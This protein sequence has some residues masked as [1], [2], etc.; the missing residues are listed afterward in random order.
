MKAELVRCSLVS[1]VQLGVWNH[2][3]YRVI[4]GFSV[5]GFVSLGVLTSEFLSHSVNYTVN[6]LSTWLQG[7]RLQGM[8]SIVCL[9]LSLWIWNCAEQLKY[10]SF[11]RV[12]YFATLW[13][14]TTKGDNLKNSKQVTFKTSTHLSKSYN[15]GRQSKD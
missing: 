5:R 4:G 14:H 12:R 7:T 1:Q 13:S 15:K 6:Q 8:G 9:N 11:D 10:I 3:R 2:H